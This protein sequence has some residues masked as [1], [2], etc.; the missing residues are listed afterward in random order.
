MS[1]LYHQRLPFEL[2]GIFKNASSIVNITIP[3]AIPFMFHLTST[4]ANSVLPFWFCEEL[5]HQ[6]Q[7]LA[8]QS[9]LLKIST[10]V[11]YV[12]WL[13]CEPRELK[14]LQIDIQKIANFLSRKSISRLLSGNTM[15]ATLSGKLI[16]CSCYGSLVHLSAS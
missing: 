4:S 9:C 16:V 8:M 3:Y 15:W 10:E 13:L 2:F 7:H 1:V 5:L 14:I 6:L 12:I 11:E